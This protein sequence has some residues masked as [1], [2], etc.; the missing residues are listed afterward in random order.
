MH[1]VQAVPLNFIQ[2]VWRHFRGRESAVVT[3]ACI[4]LKSIL[5]RCGHHTPAKTPLVHVHCMCFCIAPQCCVDTVGLTQVQPQTPTSMR[6]EA[7]EATC[8][9]RSLRCSRA[10]RGRTI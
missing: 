2:G 7:G 8:I 4:L 5:L 3:S 1:A 10:L 9:G 6:Q